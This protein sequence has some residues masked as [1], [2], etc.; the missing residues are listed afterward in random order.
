MLHLYFTH[1]LSLYETL[2]NNE[3]KEKRY[4]D[5]SATKELEI[6]YISGD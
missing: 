6:S 3:I 4:L 5:E 1:F 2:Q